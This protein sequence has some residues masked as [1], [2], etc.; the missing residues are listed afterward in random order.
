MFYWFLKDYE[1]NIFK[2]NERKVETLYTWEKVISFLLIALSIVFF[3]INIYQLGSL[4]GIIILIGL[5]AL[6]ITFYL[7]EENRRKKEFDRI[8][9]RFKKN[10]LEPFISMLQNEKYTMFGK[11]LDC[12]EGIEW[13]LN[14]CSNEIERCNNKPSFVVPIK[15][16]LTFILPIITY[17][18]GTLV[19]TLSNPEKLN[20][21]VMVLII[22]LMIFGIYCIVAPP[23]NDFL[24]KQ[25]KI[26]EDLKDNLEYYKM[27]K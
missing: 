7:L 27:T 10:K 13:L 16:F 2:A 23:L 26:I 15:S 14:A 20:F 6:L 22:L 21:S 5:I 3:F 9:A 18:G 17:I 4:A 25:I 19:S 12:E 24:S 8:V 11:T 1:T